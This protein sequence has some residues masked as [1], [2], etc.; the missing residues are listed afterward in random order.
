MSFP[1]D[2][3]MWFRRPFGPPPPPPHHRFLMEL[4]HGTTCASNGKSCLCCCGHYIPNVETGACEDLKQ[5][6]PGIDKMVDNV[7][8]GG[9]Y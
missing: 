3:P 9:P 8:K 2:A 4:F 1:N 7:D 6:L 5:L